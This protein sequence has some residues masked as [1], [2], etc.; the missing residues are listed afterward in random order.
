C[1]SKNEDVTAYISLINESYPE[2]RRI[3]ANIF[4]S[5]VY[6][7]LV[8]K[9]MLDELNKSLELYIVNPWRLPEI[10]SFINLFFTKTLC[11]SIKLQSSFKIDEHS[12]IISFYLKNH[13]T[14]IERINQLINIDKIFFIDKNVQRIALHSKQYRK[15]IDELIQDDKSITVDK[16][17][18]EQS[19]FLVTLNSKTKNLK[20]PGLNMDLLSSSSSYLL[21][22]QQQEHITNIILNDYFQDNNI[23][24]LDKLKCLRVLRRFSCTYN[25]TLEW[26]QNKQTSQL[27]IK[28]SNKTPSWK[29]RGAAV[30]P[31]DDIILCLPATFNLNQEYLLKHFDLLKTNLNTSNARFISDAILN[32]SRKIPNE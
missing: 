11:S 4:V 18:N 2:T 6:P 26:I 15:F 24:N 21:T 5:D 7:K 28:N 1:Y 8:S 20:W 22:E 25:K 12:T 27:L 16:L 30:A 31:I 10:D 19:K 9:L 29:T 13:L 32:I 17:S 23:S 3:L 14:Q